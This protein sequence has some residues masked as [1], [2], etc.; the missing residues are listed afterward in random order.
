VFIIIFFFRSDKKITVDDL[1]LLCDL[2]YLPFEHGS[3][4]LQILNEFYWLKTN[5][6]VIIGNTK[7]RVD[8]CAM[9]PEVIFFF[10]F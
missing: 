5:A 7:K 3:K 10:Y 8:S 1:T 6:N 2:F 9:K 4:A